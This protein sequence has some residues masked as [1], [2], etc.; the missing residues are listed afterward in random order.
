MQ[1]CRCAS[2]MIQMAS[3]AVR[4][5]SPAGPQGGPQKLVVSL[6][7]VVSCSS[8]DPTMG[9]AVVYFTKVQSHI[10]VHL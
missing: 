7:Y 1:S 10:R 3:M 5:T 8:T 6:T 9:Q 2:S 4:P